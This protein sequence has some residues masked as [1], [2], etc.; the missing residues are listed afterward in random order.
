MPDNPIILDDLEKPV[1]TGYE[2]EEINEE[3]K[4]NDDD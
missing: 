1:N 2:K 3:D 4:G